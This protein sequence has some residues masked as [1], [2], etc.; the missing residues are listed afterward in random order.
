MHGTPARYLVLID[1]AGATTAR[2]FDAQRRPLGDYDASSEETATMT[3][4][5]T[6]RPGAAGAEWDAALAGHSAQ[7]RRGAEIFELDL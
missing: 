7:E 1:N 5:L 6:G 4:G 2:L 3:K